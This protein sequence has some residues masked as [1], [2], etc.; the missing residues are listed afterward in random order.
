MDYFIKVNNDHIESIVSYEETVKET[1]QYFSARLLEE[2]ITFI[3]KCQSP[4]ERFMASNLYGLWMVAYGVS[5]PFKLTIVPQ[6]KFKT[7]NKTYTVDFYIELTWRRKVFLLIV[8]C[9]GHEFHEKTREQASKDKERDRNLVKSGC[10]V[11]RYT[12]S[13][14]YNDV[15]KCVI[16]IRDLLE[17]QVEKWRAEIQ[18]AE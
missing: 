5:S 12:G 15:D 2:Y 18:R 3:N 17:S 10:A 4:I 1:I 6:Y 13:E 7:P 16:E 8:E 14:I 11:L 9:D